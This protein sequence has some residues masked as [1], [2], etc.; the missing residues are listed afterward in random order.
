[1]S[2]PVDHPPPWEWR[3]A[4]DYVTG[5]R[6]TLFAPGMRIPGGWALLDANGRTLVDK[7]MVFHLDGQPGLREQIRAAPEMEQ[8]LWNIAEE[9]ALRDLDHNGPPDPI[10]AKIKAVL[11]PIDAAKN[12]GG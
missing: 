3:R 1:M 10:I 7:E 12:A 5:P 4:P 8:L 2:A 11:R 9:L 6:D